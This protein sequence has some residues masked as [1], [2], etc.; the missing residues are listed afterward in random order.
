MSGQP[1][2]KRSVPRK[3]LFLAL[4]Y[5]LLLAQP[6][7]AA[8]SG[9]PELKGILIL[10]GE[11]RFS[12]QLPGEAG[13]FWVKVGDAR[14][15]LQVVAYDSQNETLE[16]DYLGERSQLTLAD[17]DSVPIPVIVSRSL[18]E[19]EKAKRRKA[20][21][22]RPALRRA[23]LTRPSRRQ[24]STSAESS[25]PSPASSGG[26]ADSDRADQN[27]RSNVDIAEATQNG[28]ALLQGGAEESVPKR[29]TRRL[30]RRKKTDDKTSP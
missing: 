1:Q 19:A 10:G 13:A 17:S 6:V 21:E 25:R 7:G 2:P 27:D 26:E 20:L 12:L 15:G 14:F 5:F 11:S 29:N 9:M 24:S 16:V 8:A 22:E 3:F 28:G 30:P 4:G 23:S 18:T